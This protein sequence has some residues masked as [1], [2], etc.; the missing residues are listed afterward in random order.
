MNN[1]KPL[2]PSPP[3]RGVFLPAAAP[4]AAAAAAAAAVGVRR[5][6]AASAG[7]GLPD[8]A[9]SSRGRPR[10][11]QPHQPSFQSAPSPSPSSS[12]SSPP[13]PPPAAPPDSVGD[14]LDVATYSHDCHVR[15]PAAGKGRVTVVLDGYGLEPDGKGGTLPERVAVKPEKRGKM[16]KKAHAFCGEAAGQL[17]ENAVNAA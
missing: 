14:G 17:V 16:L 12:P 6:P 5:P 11:D 8:R 3:P 1:K 4:A 7:H 15:D 2:S 10:H 9:S 13:P